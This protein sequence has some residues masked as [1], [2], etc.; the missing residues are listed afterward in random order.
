[1]F[2]IGLLCRL[3]LSLVNVEL[4]DDHVT[5][6]LLWMQDGHFPGATDCWECFQPPLFY[7]I[8]KSIAQPFGLESASDILTI[9]RSINFLF[10]STILWL[11]LKYMSRLNLQQAIK[12]PFMLFWALNPEL[13]SI[14]G[15][16]T[17]DTW[18]ILLGL[19]LYPLLEQYWLSQGKKHAAI[20]L[21]IITI[22]GLSKGNGLVLMLGFIAMFCMLVM[23]RKFALKRM[24]TTLLGIAVSIVLIAFGGLYVKKQKDHGDPFIINQTKPVQ[25]N[26]W[27]AD[28]VF[29]GRPGVTS[30]AETFFTFRFINLMEEPFNQNDKIYPKHRTSFFT[31]LYGQ[32]SNYFFESHPASWHTTN[33]DAKN[34]ILVNYVIHLP[35]FLIFVLALL[36][37]GIR[38][39]KNPF[40]LQTMHGFWIFLFLAFVIRYSYIY[41]DFSNMKLLFMFPVLFA[42][43]SIF[44][45]GMEWIN[46]PKIIAP[47]LYLASILYT[48]NFVYLI[49]QLLK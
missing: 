20:I 27:K 13:I 23:A 24:S 11:M 29:Q 21:I 39:F 2:G 41:R 8:I 6:I 14:G 43:I 47:L 7:G 16:N 38:S 9:I 28:T 46:R 33:N 35:L 17:N 32:Y 15:L 49:R 42:L 37:A 19:I 1:M 31:Q 36:V 34:F 22:A 5:P 10:S 40:S 12:I 3:I 25:A 44:K 4:N 45:A 30:V 26:F 18:L 48:V